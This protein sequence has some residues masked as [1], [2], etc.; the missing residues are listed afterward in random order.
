MVIRPAFHALTIRGRHNRHCLVVCLDG[1]FSSSR[2][3]IQALVSSVHGWGVFLAL[4]LSLSF[5]VSF[6]PLFFFYISASIIS[7]ADEP[8]PFTVPQIAV[9]FQTPSFFLFIISPIYPSPIFSLSLCREPRSLPSVLSP[10]C[11]YV[12]RCTPPV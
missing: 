1:W 9:S 4:S 3:A 7:A 11:V 10:M 6:P 2:R 12:R 5:R 8:L